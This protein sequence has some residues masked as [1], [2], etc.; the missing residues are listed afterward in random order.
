MAKSDAAFV[1]AVAVLL[2]LAVIEAIWPTELPVLVD[3]SM[4][5]AQADDT[6]RAVPPIVVPPPRCEALPPPV[7]PAPP[8][9][10]DWET[11]A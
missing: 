4:T 11:K 10:F 8:S 1:F 5:S 7:F 6:K 2:L 9:P 3:A